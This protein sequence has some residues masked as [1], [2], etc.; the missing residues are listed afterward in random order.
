VQSATTGQ[1]LLKRYIGITPAAQCTGTRVHWWLNFWMC[2]KVLRWIW[3]LLVL[4][5]VG[6]NHTD[7]KAISCSSSSLGATSWVMLIYTTEDGAVVKR[8]P[9]CI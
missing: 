7:G 2:I 4:I 1:L 3:Y 8:T 9:R 5:C 6:E